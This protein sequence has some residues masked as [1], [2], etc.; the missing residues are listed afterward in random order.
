MDRSS[1]CRI[2]FC[3][4]YIE[5]SVTRRRL[6]HVREGVEETLITVLILQPAL[7]ARLVG[8]QPQHTFGGKA[9]CLTRGLGEPKR[10]FEKRTGTVGMG[11]RVPSIS[12]PP[13]AAALEAC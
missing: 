4:A 10:S 11:N 6:A 8:V 5:Y 1:P 13:D 12:R 2:Y 3:R 7:Y 9:V